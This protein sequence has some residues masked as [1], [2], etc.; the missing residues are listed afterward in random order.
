MILRFLLV[1]SVLLFAADDVPRVIAIQSDDAVVMPLNP[2]H[3]FTQQQL[4]MLH[5]L[6]SFTFCEHMH[7]THAIIDPVIEVK[8]Q[9]FMCKRTQALMVR[10]LRRRVTHYS[11]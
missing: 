6:Y 1:T 9:Q 5:G 8:F 2:R 11:I 7:P 4:I 3:L 10:W